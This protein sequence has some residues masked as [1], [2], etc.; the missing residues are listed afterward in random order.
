M[1]QNKDT[2]TIARL[3][4]A[5]PSIAILRKNDHAAAPF[6]QAKSG[7]HDQPLRAADA[8]IRVEEDDGWSVCSSG[9]AGGV[10]C[11][12]SRHGRWTRVLVESGRSAL[13]VHVV[14]A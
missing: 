2:H 5:M 13:P 7:V 14:N 9:C 3:L 8:E 11:S 10:C 4:K 12:R 1:K 6:L